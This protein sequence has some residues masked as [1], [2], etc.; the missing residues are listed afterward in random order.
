MPAEDAHADV[1]EDISADTIT[2]D[3]V[4]EADSGVKDI[5]LGDIKIDKD[6]KKVE[7]E[8]KESPGCSCVF[9]E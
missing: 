2:T 1:P 5:I 4:S 3:A 6:A 9:I 7:T 8:K